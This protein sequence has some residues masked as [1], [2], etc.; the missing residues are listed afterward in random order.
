LLVKLPPEKA[1]V[2][3]DFR[4]ATVQEVIVFITVTLVLAFI[5][6]NSLSRAGVHGFAHGFYRFFAWECML[7][8]FVLDMHTWNDAPDSPHQILAGILFFCSLLLVLS[9][10]ALLQWMGKRDANRDDVP[11]LAF[12]KT[13]ALV[14]N[15]I[16]R[17]IR[18]PMYGS[19]FLLC[20]GFFSKQPS[21]EGSVL[22]VI[23]SLFLT[24]TSR[25]EEKENL[26]YFGEAYSAYMKRTK[27]FVPFIL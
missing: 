4:S 11:M 10:L 8:L 5:S 24:A 23:A 19:L 12:E 15:G 22:A 13:T 18:H 20:W 27:M 14:T 3:V 1:G 16:Y 17:Y 6:R 21:L 25:V 7:G 2:S 26:S 9:S